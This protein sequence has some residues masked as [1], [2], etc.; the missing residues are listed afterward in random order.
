MKLHLAFNKKIIFVTDIFFVLV[1]HFCSKHKA[2]C[3]CKLRN[4]KYKILSKGKNYDN[5][6]FKNLNLCDGFLES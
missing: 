6:I 2:M 5:L 4:L 3:F 1:L